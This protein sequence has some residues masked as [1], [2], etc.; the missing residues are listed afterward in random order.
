M[1][2]IQDIVKNSK[3]KHEITCV[4]EN[5]YYESRNQSYSGRIAVAMV[6]MNRAKLSKLPAC[7][8]VYARNDRGCQFTWTC[9][10]IKPVWES[11]AW[12][13]SLALAYISYNN[14]V[15]DITSGATYYYNP[16]VVNPKWAINKIPVSNQYMRN[17][18]L[19]DHRFLKPG[20]DDV[21][22]M[23]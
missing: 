11:A 21:Y 15:S 10:K 6:T 9:S 17:G 3:Q 5:I 12:K 14:V 23:R 8:I 7:K 16:N 2:R 1:D 18:L 13:E 4:A 19:G 20:R 22:A